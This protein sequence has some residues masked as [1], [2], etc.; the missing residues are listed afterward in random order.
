MSGGRG[1]AAVLAA[2]LVVGGGSVR[3]AEA[4]QADVPDAVAAAEALSRAAEW[5]CA[6]VMPSVVEIE[7]ERQVRVSADPARRSPRWKSRS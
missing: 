4:P 2:L 3:A 1:V 6:C 7:T 5:A